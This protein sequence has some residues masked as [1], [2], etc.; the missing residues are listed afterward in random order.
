MS[1]RSVSVAEAKRH[2]SDL[3]GRVVYGNEVITI[4]KRGKPIA[5][6]V[7][8]KGEDVEMHLAEAKGWL[9]E[10]DEFF[11]TITQIVENRKKHKPR[12]LGKK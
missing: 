2:L 12:I 8:L 10:D 6:L 5:K 3:L 9:D 1:N 7:P 4:T 11:E